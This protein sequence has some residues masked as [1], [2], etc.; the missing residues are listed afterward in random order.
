MLRKTLFWP[1][2]MLGAMLLLTGCASVSSVPLALLYP[3]QGVLRLQPGETY[4]AH[5]LETWHSTARYEA[6]ELQLLDATSA[7]RQLQA[8]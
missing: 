2:E 6:L 7:L 3:P 1:L 4:Q 8:K 5:T